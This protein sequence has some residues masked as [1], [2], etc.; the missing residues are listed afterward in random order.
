MRATIVALAGLASFTAGCT[1]SLAVDATG[2]EIPTKEIYAS[3]LGEA[4]GVL[5][6][7][8][9]LQGCVLRVETETTTSRFVFLQNNIFRMEDSSGELMVQGTYR[10]QGNDICAGWSPRDKKF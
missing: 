6:P 8:E 9:E 3:T 7:G 1:N 5:S 2:A 10:T 4:A